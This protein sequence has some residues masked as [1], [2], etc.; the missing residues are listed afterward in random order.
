MEPPP[1]QANAATPPK[2]TSWQ[3]ITSLILGIL[4][5][6]G[7]SFLTGIPAIILGIVGLSKV[8]NNQDVG[9]K[10][11]SVAGIVL[12]IIGSL[13]ILLLF[14]GSAR[15]LSSAKNAS[16]R[17][18]CYNLKNAMS[19]YFTEYR[20][21]PLKESDGVLE[22]DANFMSV[23]L[24]ADN[25]IGKKANPREIVFFYGSSARPDSNGK[26]RSGLE[27]KKMDRAIFGIPGEICIG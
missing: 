23:I 3:A 14:F 25:E 8:K 11:L 27:K 17:N 9:G 26:F 2:Q 4:S 15:V 21:H 22:T 1:H 7:L 20:S 6:F 18:T 10:G 5:I 13:L 16:A 24:A 19:A 12:G